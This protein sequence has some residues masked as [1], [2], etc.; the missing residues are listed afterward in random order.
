M[1]N[2]QTPPSNRGL[3]LQVGI[4]YLTFT[5]KFADIDSFARFADDLAE[6][7]RDRINWAK[8]RAVK[9]GQYYPHGF[10]SLSGFHLA[11]KT[12][13]NSNLIEAIFQLSGSIVNTIPLRQLLRYCAYT[14]FPL[15]VFVTRF[16]ICSDDHTG[17]IFEVRQ[18]I[19][20][21]CDM[22]ET[23]PDAR[24]LTPGFRKYHFHKSSDGEFTGRTLE[25]GSRQSQKF[26][27][28]YDKR[29]YTPVEE[30]R[31]QEKRNREREERER[32]MEGNVSGLEGNVEVMEGNVQD[33]EGCDK[34]IGIC[35]YSER[36]SREDRREWIRKQKRNIQKKRDEKRRDFANRLSLVRSG[37]REFINDAP[38]VKIYTRWET[39]FKSESAN[40]LFTLICNL[41]RQFSSDN[42]VQE[43]QKLFTDLM[44]SGYQFLEER[45]HAS[46][47]RENIVASW[48][49]EFLELVQHQKVKLPK[50]T[51]A[52]SIQK[53][54]DFLE[55]QAATSIAMVSKFYGIGFDNWLYRLV[56]SGL[57]RMT[58][59]QM[60][61]LEIAMSQGL[62][63]F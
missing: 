54:I 11:Y 40:N 13:E 21:L 36:K 23:N 33:V 42:I 55:R 28:I 31:I 44:F 19:S 24:K 29:V 51:P 1:K 43:I 22:R 18:K 17:K 49:I 14:L 37:E 38:K 47:D 5:H 3:N 30:K 57:G 27:R 34:G 2:S 35:Q 53:T 8:D 25:L 52:K 15:G 62:S 6:E 48:W 39:E 50:V 9:I 56:E 41:Y 45:R 12:S 16:D 58:E 10:R 4:D 59:E 7:F 60:L 20:D 46:L 61:M 63:E 26:S 32:E